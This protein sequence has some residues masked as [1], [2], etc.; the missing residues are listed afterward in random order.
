MDLV[1]KAAPY[2]PEGVNFG[3]YLVSSWLRAKYLPNPV[4]LE[5]VAKTLAVP[6]NEL[7]PAGA[8]TIVKPGDKDVQVSMSSSGQSRIKLDMELPN[9]LVLQI[10]AIVN[11]A[12]KGAHG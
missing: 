8:A 9:E 11:K 4:N 6:S 1:R 5:I 2:V 10:M 7:L 12:A 3:R